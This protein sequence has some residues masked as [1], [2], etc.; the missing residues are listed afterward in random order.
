MKRIL[1]NGILLTRAKVTGVERFSRDQIRLLANAAKEN[2][3]LIFVLVNDA[4]RFED[5]PNVKYIGSRYF[6][7]ISLSLFVPFLKILYRCEA[8]ISPLSLPTFIPTASDIYT[9]HD[10]AWKVM[11]DYFPKLKL[12]YLNV[13]H[14]LLSI[15]SSRI[16][17]VSDST[18]RDFIRYYSPRNT[19]RI[20]ALNP[21]LDLESIVFKTSRK[22]PYILFIGTL[23]KRKNIYFLLSN[24]DRIPVSF[25][26]KIVGASG[27][28][29]N[30]LDSVKFDK[31]RVDFLGYVDDVT[32]DDLL[33]DAFAL[34]L[35]SLYEGWGYPVCDAI[36][37]GTP[38]ITPNNSSF[39]E[40]NRVKQLIYPNNDFDGFLLVF[41]YLMSNYQSVLESMRAARDSYDENF[42]IN[43]Y[44]T[45]VL[46]FPK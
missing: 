42:Y 15:C 28:F 11:P 8:F 26:L 9:V 22:Q 10:V 2:N 23:Q 33:N 19:N 39:P 4:T 16:H 37:S 34:V 27:W 1:Y 3:Y 5:C 17:C 30:E 43:S 29:S 20:V 32:R 36:A 46:V 31:S 21:G 24:L 14:A 18:R 6:N 44:L 45:K 41:S 25:R 13:I 12:F 40:V 7:Q 38:A 35:P